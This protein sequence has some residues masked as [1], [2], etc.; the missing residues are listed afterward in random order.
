MNI[1]NFLIPIKPS[2]EILTTLKNRCVIDPDQGIIT[3][4]ETGDTRGSLN[5]RGYWIVSIAGR[6]MKRSHIIWWFVTGEWP[7]SEIDHDD[8]V[9]LNDRY[10][11]LKLSSRIE[12]A[13]NTYTS[14]DRELPVGV[15]LRQDPTMAVKHYIVQVRL[16]G[17]QVTLR[18]FQLDQ[19]DD[20]YRLG[21]L[22]QVMRRTNP[23]VTKQEI[24]A[25][26]NGENR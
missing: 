12:Q 23:N 24:M 11:N 18:Y 25:A 8:R 13:Q 20:A 16:Q 9:P 10:S 2:D 3:D 6:Q 7:T 22:A 15:Y 26:F 1:R 5:D 19:K 4:R 17:K 21:A 14:L